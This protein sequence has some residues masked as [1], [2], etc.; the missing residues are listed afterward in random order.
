M[1]QSQVAIGSGGFLGKGLGKGTQVQ[2]DFLPEH[3]TD[4]I[5][6]VVGEETGFVGVVCLLALYLALILRCLKIAAAAKEKFGSLICIG[7]TAI[8]F[9]Q[10]FI[11]VGM[12]IG[13]MPITGITM[14]LLSYGGSSMLMNLISLG[15]IL[16][17]DIHSEKGIF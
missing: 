12:T 5:F 16:S 3:H 6:S 13:L 11:N 10:V 1:I 7:I 14:P 4:F 8:L 2:G 15:I 9:F 17:V